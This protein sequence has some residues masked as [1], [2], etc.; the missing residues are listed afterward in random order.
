MEPFREENQNHLRLFVIFFNPVHTGYQETTNASENNKHYLNQQ[1]GFFKKNPKERSAAY[2]KLTDNATACVLTYLNYSIKVILMRHQMEAFNE[3]L[4]TL[5]FRHV[6]AG[7]QSW[8]FFITFLYLVTET[9]CLVIL[10][11]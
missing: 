10:R 6:L 5:T 8:P 4:Y 1:V 2:M 7:D 11:V 9:L 3:Q